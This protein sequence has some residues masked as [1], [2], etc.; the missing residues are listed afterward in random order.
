MMTTPQKSNK[1]LFYEPMIQKDLIE[2]GIDLI[3]ANLPEIFA[4][5]NTGETSQGKGVC[6][7]GNTGSGK[8]KRLRWMA[9]A[10]NIRM[11]PA[12]S[13]CRELVDCET[14]MDQQELLGCLPPRWDVVPK[15][16]G[17]LIIDDLG[18]EPEVNN[19]YGTKYN[20]LADAIEYRYEKFPQFKTHF[21]TNLTKKKLEERYGERVFSRL[22]EMVHFVNLSGIDRRRGV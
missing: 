6:F 12:K 1:W 14:E 17:D 13:L 22:C 4:K 5:I 7:L 20:I 18:S 10:F 15:H 16:Y 3:P 8:T 21:T 2:E 11:I 19:V 9:Q